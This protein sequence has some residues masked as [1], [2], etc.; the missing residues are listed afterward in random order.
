MNNN[1]LNRKAKFNYSVEAK[2]ITGIVLLGSE[3]KSIRE[4][5]INFGDSYCLFINNELWIR[6]LHISEYN[7]GASHEVIRDRKLLL[8]KA[9]IRKIQR[10]IN[11]Q[12][13]IIF[14][15]S[16]F[17][18]DKNLIKVEIAIGKGKKNYDKREIIKKRDIER[19]LKNNNT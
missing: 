10:L 4:G 2:Y 19:G 8:N 9:E 15:L 11:E 16:I 17:L 6:G 5:A 12:G 13:F 18:T 3:V 14:P 1:L 7:H